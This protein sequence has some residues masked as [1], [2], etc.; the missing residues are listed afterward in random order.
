MCS[1]SMNESPVTTDGRAATSTC[2]NAKTLAGTSSA[3]HLEL[4]DNLLH[5]AR[6][7]RMKSKLIVYTLQDETFHT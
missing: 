6:A 5:N 7:Y 1:H 2:V 4:K 3:N